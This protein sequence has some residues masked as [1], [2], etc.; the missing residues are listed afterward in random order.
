MVILFKEKGRGGHDHIHPFLY[1][2]KRKWRGGH[3]N[4]HP[5]LKREAGLCGGMAVVVI[6]QESLC[7]WVGHNGAG[8]TTWRGGWHGGMREWY[9]RWYDNSSTRQRWS[10]P[11]P[12]VKWRSVVTVTPIPLRKPTRKPK[13]R[14]QTSQPASQP[15]SQQAIKPASLPTWEAG[16]LGGLL[17]FCK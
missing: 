17:F 1:K 3:D 11:S 8:G 9:R 2:Y 4:N 13:K 10:L 7:G 12:L 5:C 6:R 15:P 14:S 16:W